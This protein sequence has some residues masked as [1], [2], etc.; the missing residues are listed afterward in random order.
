MN[1]MT[2]CVIGLTLAVALLAVQCAIAAPA[3]PAEPTVAN[4]GLIVAVAK[5][6]PPEIRTAAE[7]IQAAAKEQPLLKVLAGTHELRVMDT[8]TLLSS[9]YQDRAFNHLVIIGLPDDPLVAKVWQREAA[10]EPDGI[11]VFGFGHFKGDIGY[12]ESDRNP[13]L[14]SEA[15]ARAPYETEVVTI[16]GT[17]PAGVALAVNAFIHHGIINGVIAGKGW[18]RP[19]PS[20]LDRDPLAPDAQLPEVPARVGE[21]PLIGVS[22]ASED[23]Y[24]NVQA[25]AGVEPSAIWRFKYHL[26]G[27]WDTAGVEAAIPEYLAGLHRRAY[28]DTVWAG[29]FASPEA[30]A[31]AAE[32]IVAAAGLT[33]E[34]DEK[35]K[36][37][38]KPG[39][40]EPNELWVKGSTVYM[41][42]LRR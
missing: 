30:A 25:D 27:D 18:S 1:G 13:F 16:T 23:E 22:Q 19:T 28:A 4:R 24:R 9:P 40:G 36:G 8:A 37:N 5:D 42:D 2:S 10:I 35:W 12:I 34:G 31:T 21:S 32:K 20:L 17:T 29:V 11:F 15:V 6:A 14:H 39:S 26:K 41:T 7:A 38:G 33:K 3:K